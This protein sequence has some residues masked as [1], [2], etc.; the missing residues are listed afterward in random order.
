MVLA[1]LPTADGAAFDHFANQGDAGCHPNTRVA[2]LAQIYE[3]ANNPDSNC[4]YWLQG[5]A[6]TGK[7]TIARTV[8]HELN[9]GGA[10]GASFFFKRGGGDRGNAT[11]FFT[12][13]TAQLVRKL[14]PLAQHVQRAIEADPDIGKGFI[15]IQ[16]DK[17]FLQALK[18][19]N[20][21]PQ[22]PL[23]TMVI[24]IDALDECD[25][26]SHA[27]TIISLLPQVKQL[28]S[29]SLKFFVTSRPEFPIRLQFNQ[30]SGTYQDLV[31]HHVNE[32][33]IEHDIHIFLESELS[34]FR[35]KYNNFVSKDRQL[36]SDWPGQRNLQILVKMAIPLFIFAATISRFLRDWKGGRHPD[37][38][39]EDIFKYQTRSQTSK[40]DA[41]YAPV[42]D[43]LLI[44][45][46]RL[47]Q[48]DRTTH[49]R[50]IVGP[51]IVLAN[52]LSSGSLSRLLGIA[53]RNPE[54]LP[55]TCRLGKLQRRANIHRYANFTR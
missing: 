31:L 42:L 39:L 40:L 46:S 8:A 18:E 1:E 37:K 19:V 38:K 25:P 6:G 17:L 36:S 53:I 50:E 44:D 41:T 48:D 13:I 23:T 43:Q 14:P 45:L 5:M 7:S 20:S 55:S 16:F 27:T 47:A 11:R 54:S 35:G 34:E 4:I 9:K 28:S 49:F 52:P 3:W 22:S 21:D 15:N 24:V 51:I 30:I 26:E 2:L 33:I 29:V 10:L 32:D 12:T